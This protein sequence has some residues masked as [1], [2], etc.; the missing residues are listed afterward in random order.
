M[1]C[2]ICRD[3]TKDHLKD[4]DDFAIGLAKHYVDSWFTYGNTE[5]TIEKFFEDHFW[6]GPHENEPGTH[7]IL[8]YESY[9]NWRLNKYGKSLQ[10]TCDFRVPLSPKGGWLNVKNLMKEEYRIPDPACPKHGKVPVK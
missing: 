10:C 4:F 8:E 2:P 3:E 9:A 7:F 1:V 6:C 5:K